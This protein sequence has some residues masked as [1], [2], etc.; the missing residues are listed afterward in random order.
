MH[1]TREGIFLDKGGHEFSGGFSVE[2]E[3]IHFLEEALCVA[4][5]TIAK[6]EKNNGGVT[7]DSIQSLRSVNESMYQAV[8][9]LAPFGIGN[10]KPIFQ[11]TD[12]LLV[13]A[14]LFGKERNHVKLIMR[15]EDGFHKEAI[16]FFR[17]LESFPGVTLEAGARV[18]LLATIEK[19]YFRSSGEIRLRIVDVQ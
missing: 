18:T 7:P 6:N 2:G 14:E 10:P 1:A 4:H 8:N 3:A 5:K 12:V 19:S 11:F 15:D 17:T 13:R 16:A 9:L